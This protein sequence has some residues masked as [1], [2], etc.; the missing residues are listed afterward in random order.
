[1]RI[2]NRKNESGQIE[3]RIENE[4]KLVRIFIA[5]RYTDEGFV[6]Q[7]Q[8]VEHDFD[9]E[10]TKIIGKPYYDIQ[11]RILGQY[12]KSEGWT[13]KE[14]VETHTRRMAW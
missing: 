6:K 3:T 1:M 5:D 11:G 12:P 4:S 7:I 13:K 10:M 14:L 8:V 9:A 2:S